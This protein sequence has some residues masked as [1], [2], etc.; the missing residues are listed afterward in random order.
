MEQLN[1]TAISVLNSSITVGSASPAST[2]HTVLW[3]ILFMFLV[4]VACIPGA[5]QCIGFAA[6]GVV[7]GSFAA[8]WQSSIAIANG[9]GVVAG[10]LFAILQSIAMGGFMCAVAWLYVVIALAVVTA[11][12][13]IFARRDEMVAWFEAGFEH[14]Y[15]F[16]V[17]V[18]KEILEWVNVGEWWAKAGSSSTYA[19]LVSLFARRDEMAAWFEAGF[20]HAH[21]FVVHVWKEI[22]EWVNVGEWW[23]KAGSSTTYVTHMM[24]AC[25]GRKC[26]S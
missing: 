7:A 5:L 20:E 8:L 15:A 23:A 17:H 10:S 6:E 2:H 26:L 14:A 16:V 24:N 22:L 4:L 1:M 3:I 12:V 11:L 25:T 9:V 19:A 21:A 13:S 18:W